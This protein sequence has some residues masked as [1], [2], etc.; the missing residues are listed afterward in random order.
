MN[1]ML[2]LITLIR[3]LAPVIAEAVQLIEQLFPEPG[4]GSKKLFL[5][6]DLL[7]RLAGQAGVAE[8]ELR[9]N[10]AL[11]EQVT[12]WIVGAYNHFGKFKTGA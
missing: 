3:T 12:T 6:K 11:I 7:F 2:A 1:Q 8:N 4:Q 10:A 5:L 9:D